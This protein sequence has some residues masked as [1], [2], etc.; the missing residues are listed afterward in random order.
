MPRDGYGS[1]STASRP[2]NQ[3]VQ[4]IH[5]ETLH[6]FN[7]PTRVSFVPQELPTA[8][9]ATP[10]SQATEVEHAETRLPEAIAA[11]MAASTGVEPKVCIVDVDAFQQLDP[12]WIRMEQRGWW[13]LTAIVT[14]IFFGVW[15]L[16]G[17]VF[18]QAFDALQWTL[19]LFVSSVAAAGFYAS[20][21]V[22]QRTFQSTS[23]QLRAN[24]LEIRR[25]IWW[26]HRI[27]IPRNQIQH[28]DVQQGPVM[29]MFGLSTL[30]INTG[31]THEP[32]IP[33]SGLS[34]AT[35]ESIRGQLTAAIQQANILERL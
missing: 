14:L 34:L 18:R 5:F 19:L 17:F 11:E 7:R 9:S 10:E 26:Q 35:A 23:W 2:R 30:V 16:V 31:G 20:R 8:A 1:S 21:V 6:F 32:S 29:R 24:G 28:T 13:I 27:F 15:L 25:G 4:R 22:P 12:R 33:L 3:N